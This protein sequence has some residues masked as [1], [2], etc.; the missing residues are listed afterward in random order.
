MRIIFIFLFVLNLFANE[1]IK[2]D[3]EIKLNLPELNEEEITS[4]DIFDNSDEYQMNIA[5][6]L[7]KQKFFKFIP[8]ILNSMNAYMIKK[9]INYHI[10]LFNLDSNLTEKLD[11]VTKN[12]KYVFLYSTS[13]K[14]INVTQD[15]PGTYFFIPTLNK[16]QSNI[17]LNDVYFGGINYKQQINKLNQYITDSTLVIYNAKSDLSKYIT[18]VINNTIINY[19]VR[20]IQYP[21]YGNYKTFNKR[22]VYLNTSAINSVQILSN[23]TYHKVETKSIL[24]TQL[25][26]TPILF[27]LTNSDDTKDLIIANSIFNINNIIEDNNFNLG[28]NIDF[29]WLNYTTSTLLNVAYNIETKTDDIHYLNDFDLYMFFNQVDY[30][31][32]L[33]RIFQKG[34]IQIEN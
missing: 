26:Y 27:L 14:D 11:E 12:Y 1:N 4:D 10:K 21:I 17:R 19:P 15:Y 31:T 28:N 23:F 30:K 16:N 7:D 32:N 5:V 8:N 6:F 3:S 25:N 22:Y 34:F 9:D 20:N 29:N 18:Q 2:T 33:Y 24:S 13:T